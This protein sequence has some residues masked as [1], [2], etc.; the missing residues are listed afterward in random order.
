MSFYQNFADGLHIKEE[1]IDLQRLLEIQEKF[2]RIRN[3]KAL[4][5]IKR[6]KKVLE[7]GSGRGSFAKLCQKKNV[8]Y[9]GIEPEK[10]L[11]L[12]L[13]KLGFNVKNLK[14][15]PL[16]YKDSFFDYVVHFH[17]VEHLE[18]ANI[19]Y[20][21]FSEINRILKKDGKMIFRCPNALTWGFKF[22]DMDYTHSFFTTP[23]RIEQALYDSGFETI[24]FEEFSF[25]KP[26]HF[27]KLAWFLSKIRFLDNFYPKITA[28]LG[29]I[30]KKNTE[31]FYV[32]KKL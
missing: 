13:R 5:F 29:K 15:P 20:K 2:E 31:L 18:D 27:G 1:K 25:F 19:V 6:G 10:T 21:F 4:S 22:W 12:K 9:F 28:I 3:E 11:F 17:V 23:R 30:F 24:Y 16:P 26:Y 14:A 32:C 7:I 8:S